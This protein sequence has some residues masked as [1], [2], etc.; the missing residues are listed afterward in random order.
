[1]NLE[2]AER[3]EEK[4][5]QGDHSDD[6]WFL[7]QVQRD[8]RIHGMPL[9]FSAA[10]TIETFSFLR[11]MGID[12]TE[13]DD[14]R[15]TVLME[16]EKSFDIEVFRWLAD[17]FA[18]KDAIDIAEE[19]G[20]TALSTKIKFGE[21]EKARILLERGASVTTFATVARYGHARIAIANQAI[22]CIPI[23]NYSQEDTAIEAL[24]LLVEFGYSPDI[25]HSGQL[26]D[27]VPEKKPRLR[28]W[29]D[30]NIVKRK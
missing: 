16:P 18:R 12:L 26:L 11:D 3:W 13:Q 20:F 28:A 19:E 8:V 27:A 2:R 1:M 10:S 4:F 22:N 15:S 23:D 6:D 5:L 25:D 29:I 17:E 30:N 7:T 21:L 14:T 24:K 9:W